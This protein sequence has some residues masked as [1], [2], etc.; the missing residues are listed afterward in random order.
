MTINYNMHPN[1]VLALFNSTM[2]I[3]LDHG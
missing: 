1:E 3:K 2:I